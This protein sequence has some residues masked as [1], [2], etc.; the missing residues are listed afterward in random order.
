MGLL[1]GLNEVMYTK[2]LTQGLA[3]SM[4]SLSVSVV[5]NRER[6]S[7]IPLLSTASTLTFL[8]TKCGGSFPT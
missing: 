7:S 3:L 1:G 4:Y 2:R 6:K 8:A 5:S